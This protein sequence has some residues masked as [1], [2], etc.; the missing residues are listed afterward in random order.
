MVRGRGLR[1]AWVRRRL[2]A[3]LL[4]EQP[5]AHGIIAGRGAR[6]GQTTA[7][8]RVELSITG[9]NGTYPV[10]DGDVPIDVQVTLGGQPEAAA[11]LCTESAFVPADCFYNAGRNQ[12]T[13]KK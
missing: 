6:P 12:L 8:R 3:A 5:E 13:C 11:G 1:S 9:D 2:L 4:S 7:P 10:V